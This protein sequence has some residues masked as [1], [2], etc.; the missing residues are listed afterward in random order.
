VIDFV[1]IDD[2]T[3]AAANRELV[4]AFDYRGLLA[5]A[6]GLMRLADRADRIIA[7]VREHPGCAQ[8]PAATA[9]AQLCDR[10]DGCEIRA[11]MQRLARLGKI[12]VEW[13]EGTYRYYPPIPPYDEHWILAEGACLFLV[14][15]LRIIHGE[16]KIYA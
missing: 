14:N 7:Y 1:D 4:E 3:I 13:D 15:L 10:A 11:M 6:G 12:R 8:T 16:E 5:E 9:I 2:P